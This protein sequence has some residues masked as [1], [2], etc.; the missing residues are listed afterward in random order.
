M[1]FGFRITCGT[2]WYLCLA[3]VVFGEDEAAVLESFAQFGQGIGVSH[4]VNAE[5][6][7]YRLTREVVLGRADAAAGN[8]DI[9]AI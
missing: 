3:L 7:S 8:Y 4:D 6:L 2:S 1:P 9:G 5:D